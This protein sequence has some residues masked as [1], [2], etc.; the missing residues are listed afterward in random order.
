LRIPGKP[1]HHRGKLEDQQIAGLD[2]AD[3]GFDFGCKA[4]VVAGI[5]FLDLQLEEVRV[6]DRAEVTAVRHRLKPMR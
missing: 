6:F 5:G 1:N 4:V 2:L 3:L